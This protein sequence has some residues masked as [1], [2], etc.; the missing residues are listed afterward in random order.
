MSGYSQNDKILVLNAV[1]L[2]PRDESHAVS[3]QIAVFAHP[4]CAALSRMHALSPLMVRNVSANTRSMDPA[5][6]SARNLARHAV[7]LSCCTGI[8]SRHLPPPYPDPLGFWHY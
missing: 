8:V 6:E 4:S 7:S 3:E 1:F 5:N 2:L